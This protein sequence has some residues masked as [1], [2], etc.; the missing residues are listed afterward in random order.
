[1]FFSIK[2]AFWHEDGIHR[3]APSTVFISTFWQASTLSYNTPNINTHTHIFSFLQPWYFACLQVARRAI[4]LISLPP[5]VSPFPGELYSRDSKNSCSTKNW[6]RCLTTPQCF[7]RDGCKLGLE[8]R[9]LNRSTPEKRLRWV[10]TRQDETILFIYSLVRRTGLS[11]WE[12]ASV[13]PSTL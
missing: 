11:E 3:W 10:V 13:K 4:V 6:C 12:A 7:Q 9:P 2:G 5:L 8:D 1:M